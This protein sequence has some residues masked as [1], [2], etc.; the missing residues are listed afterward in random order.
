[1]K[2][3]YVVESTSESIQANKPVIVAQL[4]KKVMDGDFPT[5]PS[6]LRIQTTKT[7]TIGDEWVLTFEPKEK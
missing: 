4:S 3:T 1:M 2:Q 6:I 7:P 5:A